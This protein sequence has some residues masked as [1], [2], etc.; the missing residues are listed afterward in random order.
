MSRPIVLLVLAITVWAVYRP[1]RGHVAEVARVLATLRP[2]S[3]TFGPGAAFSA[4]VLLLT[5]GALWSARDW[6]FD[7]RLVPYAASI[8]ALVFAA[9][10]LATEIFTPAEAA[11]APAGH[12]RAIG[13][14]HIPH[15]ADLPEGALVRVRALRYFGW[16]VGLGASGMLIGFVPAIAVFVAL[17]MR[18]EFRERWR[19][20][21]LAA[22][23]VTLFL[24]GI[25]DRV[26][27]VP[28]PPSLLG[29]ALPALRQAT[30]LV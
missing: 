6:P 13:G 7:A 4:A 9:L 23:A 25:F 5:L 14:V 17:F 29:D 12:R 21:L 3:M 18:A 27:A 2:S 19:V 24:W 11:G 1:L 22:T 20:A 15:A 26:L 16:L 8:A 10:N 30:G 28:W